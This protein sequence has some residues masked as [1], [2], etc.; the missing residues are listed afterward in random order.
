MSA[1]LTR[2]LALLLFAVPLLLKGEKLAKFQEPFEFPS[3]TVAEDR[4]FVWDGRECVVHIYGRRDYSHRGQFGRRGQG[5]GDFEF[6]GFLRIFP[7]H[8]FISSGRKA[9]YFSKKGDFLRTVTP[10]YPATGSY[11]PVGSNFAGKRYLPEDP[12]ETWSEIVV[13]LFDAKFKKI[14]DL[15]SA[16]LNKIESYNFENGKRSLLV[17]GDC[18][19]LD[20][21]GDRLFVGDTTLGFFFRVFSAQGEKLYDIN[22][23]YDKRKISAG[24]RESMLEET[25]K[26]VGEQRFNNGKVRF[27]L[28]FP[29]FYPAYSD[30]MVSERQ[31]Y[32]F[33]YRPP[34]RPQEVL[35]LDLHGRLIKSATV[36][37]GQGIFT[38]EL[39]YCIYRGDVY[40]LIFNEETYKWELHSE[41][42]G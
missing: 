10:P 9:S 29:E 40:Y 16:K 14:K 11:I 15:Y 36:A 5:P 31:I 37:G 32:V 27:N 26:T 7:D 3:F 42:L 2:A 25:R 22:L 41:K 38:G 8:I 39:P 4:I 13:E 28:V 12:R 21:H 1:M 6:I 20:V 19:K 34:G 30:Y 33:L 35:I 18:F 17:V 23:P 24:D